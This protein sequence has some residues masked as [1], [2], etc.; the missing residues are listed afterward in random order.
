MANNNRV[1]SPVLALPPLEYDVQYMN[2]MIRLLNYFIE[3]QDNPG[4]MRGT[5]L[6]LTLTN[7]TIT[8]PVA[9][10]VHITDPLSALVNKTVVNIVDLPTAATGLVSGD[11]WN[12]A[13]TLKIV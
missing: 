2:N 5:G 11:V 7:N 4:S 10:I 6:V 13:G 12:S 9:S 3:Q 1:P 8:Q